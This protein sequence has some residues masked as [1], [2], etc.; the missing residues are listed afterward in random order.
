[1]APTDPSVVTER[2]ARLEGIS[3]SL[4]CAA[5]PAEVADVMLHEGLVALGAVAG[6]VVLLSEAGQTLEVLALEGY[7]PELVERWRR[8]PLAEDAPLCD[9]VRRGTPIFVENEALWRSRYAWAPAMPLDRCAWACLPLISHGRTLGGFGLSFA[10]ERVFGEDERAFMARLAQVCA[11]ALDRAG[12]YEAAEGANRANEQFLAVLSHEL[13]TP[14]TAILG[15]IQI[16]WSAPF[17]AAVLA[18]ALRVMDRNA[19]HEARL[20]D[21]ILDVSRIVADKLP[22]SLRAADLNAIAREAV[23]VVVPLA[24]AK[25]V[26][27]ATSLDY[28]P[29]IVLG[30]A[31]RLRQ[32]IG[33]LL[34]NA[35]KFTPKGGSIHIATLRVGDEARL[36]VRDT[37]QGIEADLL[38]HMFERF[39]QGDSSTT[40]AHGGLGLGLTIAK[41]LVERHCGTLTASSPGVG[42]GATFT[43]T[44]PA[45]PAGDPSGDP[46]CA[47]EATDDEL[48]P[49]LSGVRVVVVDDEPDT[50]ELIGEML[51]A[52]GATVVLATSSQQ[53][54]GILA[55]APFDVLLS[56]ISMPHEDG[57][58]LLRK[59]RALLATTGRAIP[60]AALTAHSGAEDVAR[61]LSAGFDAHVGKPL[62]LD[63]LVATVVRL[64]RLS[65]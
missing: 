14:L 7:P 49:R 36:L 60:A 37:G 40:R 26:S 30:D 1:M 20:I 59:A 24:A 41:H 13:R 8:V 52:E 51:R 50:A 65:A 9:A 23:D 28:A 62:D 61:C 4:A 2:M 38:P 39:R 3:G 57:Y 45:T 63:R 55:G 10:A 35:L 18:R 54:L 5:T 47:R 17:D 56:D 64:T 46:G 42:L 31:A 21:D 6:T 27:L 34:S 22:L 32:V 53:A 12:L 15:W 48:A 16:L 19:R 44:L 25:S 11:G 33:N 43:A 58:T 29:L